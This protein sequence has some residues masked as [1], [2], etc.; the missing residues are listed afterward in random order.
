MA[1]VWALNRTSHYT[2][3]CTD[4]LVLTDH[5]PIVGLLTKRAIG[6]IENPRLESLSEKTMRW[7]FRVEHIAGAQNFGP[8]ALSRFPC[9]GGQ[10]G[11]FG[12]VDEAWATEFEE[13]VI[14]N[15]SAKVVSVVSWDSVRKTGISDPKMASLLHHMASVDGPWPLELK[16]LEIYRTDLSNVEGVVLYKGRV[17]VPEMLRQGVLR[18]LYAAHQGTTE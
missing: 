2:L 13:G 6:E 18:S 7:N 3:G 4:L 12:S 1:I 8:D 17:L 9:P 5:K 16:E 10:V 11:T 14:A 15:A